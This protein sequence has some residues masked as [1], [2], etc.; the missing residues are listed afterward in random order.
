[1]VYLSGMVCRDLGDSLRL[2]APEPWFT[3][4]RDKLS[5]KDLKKPTLITTRI[6]WFNKLVLKVLGIRVLGYRNNLAVLGCV[7]GGD[8]DN[9][10]MVKLSNEDWYRVYSYKLPRSLALPL[11]E[12]Y[13]V[14]IYVLIGMSGIPVNL[15]TATLA[16]SALIGLLGYT[17]NPVASTAGFEASVLSNF[18]LHELLTFR[19]TGLERAFRKV[20]ERLVKYHVAS[21]TSWLSQVLMATALPAVLKM[22][23]WLAQLVGIIVGFIINFIL[24]YLY[25]WSRHRLEAR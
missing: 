5:A 20:L 4:L 18:T 9:V 22:P 10:T 21:A 16:H 14:A 7:G 3:L 6:R 8:V 19:G 2:C 13:R 24:G 11:S 15:A 12:P 23:F 25:T 1:V 17:A